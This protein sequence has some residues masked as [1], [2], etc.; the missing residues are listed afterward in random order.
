MK[1]TESRMA[2]PPDTLRVPSCPLPRPGDTVVW[3]QNSVR[4]R[5]ELVGH[6]SDGRPCIRPDTGAVNRVLTFDAIRIDLPER[7]VGPIWQSLPPTAIV[8]RPTT[9]EQQVLRQLTARLVPPGF[10]HA[11]LAEEIWQRGFEVF[12]SGSTIRKALAGEPCRDAEVVTTMPLD[13]LH[14]MVVDMYGEAQVTMGELDRPSGHLR[15][16]GLPSTTDPYADI[17]IFRYE[18]PGT[19]DAIF[20]ASFARDIMYGD[21]ACNAVYYEP[22]NGVLIDPT[23]HGLDDATE[24]CLRPVYDAT[25]RSPQ[26]KAEMGLRLIKHRILGYKMADGHKDQLAELIQTLPA[27][28]T[29]TLIAGLQAEIFTDHPK[30]IETWQLVKDEFVSLDLDDIWNEYV[31]PCWDLLS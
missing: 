13:R 4:Y 25:Y 26:E 31:S 3:Y 21:F 2:I 9:A 18:M 6:T 24:S 30:N 10:S 15:V 20:G 11:A 8:V 19:V 16:G 27:L 7:A 28:P 17:R 5:G 22:I 29:I 1:I 14:H 23:G 12:L